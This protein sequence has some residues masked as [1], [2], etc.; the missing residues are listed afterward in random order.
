MSE[1]ISHNTI[2]QMK[3]TMLKSFLTMALCGTMLVSC[4]DGIGTGFGGNGMGKIAP[5]AEV[6]ASVIT[7]RSS[8]KE[9]SEVTSSDLS[10]KLISADGTYSRSWNSVAEFPIDQDF[11]VGQYRIEVYYGSESTEGFDAPYFYGMQEIMV[12]ENEQTKVSLTATLANAMV[13]ISYSDAFINYMTDY[14]AEVHSAGGAYTEYAAG[15]TRPVY[16]KAGNVDVAVSFTK[17][18]GKGGKLEVANFTAEA[19]H[20]YH[21]NVDLAQGSGVVETI[22]VTIDESVEEET[23]KID[24]SDEVLNTSAPEVVAEGF[25]AGESLSFCPGQTFENDMVFNII[26]RGGLKELV[27]TT[28]SASLLSKGWPAEIDLMSAS[29]QQQNLLKNM[30][31]TALGV[32]NKPDKL[33]VVNMTGVLG[34][35]SYQ[36]GGDN[37]N[38]FTLVAKDKYGKMSE[39]VSLVATAE[40]VQL[41]IT[42]PILYVGGTEL[43]LDLAFNGGNTNDIVFKYR[44]SG[45]TWTVL[46]ASFETLGNNQYKVTLTVAGGTNNIVLR[47]EYGTE[48]TPEITVERKPLVVPASAE[49]NAFATKAYLP[50]TIGPKDSDTQLLTQMMNNAQVVAVENTRSETVLTAEADVANK[51]FVISGLTPGK[52]YTVKIKNGDID[53]ATA[54]A[55]TFT[56]EAATQL[57]YAGFDEWTSEKKGDYQYLW[58]VGNGSPWSTLNALTTSQSGSGSGSG[59]KTGGCAYKSTSGTIPANGRSTKSMDDGGFLGTNKSGDGHTTGDANLHNNKQHS[60]A[61]AALIRTVGWGNG[62]TASPRTSGQHFGTCDNVTPGELFLG[63]YDGQA[64]YGI[65]FT[66]RPSAMS[67]YYHYDVVSAG[68]GDYGTAEIKVLDASDNVIAQASC[69]LNEQSSYQQCVL[70]LNYE[71]ITVKA[72]KISVVFKSSGNSAALEKNTT[73]WHCPGVKNVSGGEYVGSELYIDD[74]ELIY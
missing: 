57:Q 19:R 11:A 62:N 55:K 25:T 48:I 64:N 17:P 1:I 37:T 18:N 70:N 23:V 50:V 36:E 68:N 44:N 9:Y 61:N 65:S 52:A 51:Q 49:V 30:G 54:P 15:E 60:G 20:F 14:S 7:K 66:S 16:T 29:T 34:N 28:Q 53:L 41:A 24:I 26:A 63:T 43:T 67:F 47:A 8:R 72:A 4:T 45:G 38:T 74:I 32:F 35:I 56:T 21:I 40:A 46:P 3:K 69:L 27:L 22:I 71:D 6:D 5:T 12:K 39:P 10:I 2:N 31:L 42:N 33:A 13:D 58:S 59:A 73:F